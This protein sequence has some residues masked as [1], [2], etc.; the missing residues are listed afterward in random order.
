[1]LNQ[2]PF[3]AADFPL[4]S[5]E[6]AMDARRKAQGH[7]TV[8]AEAARQLKCPLAARLNDEYAL[9][10]ELRDPETSDSGRIRLSRDLHT[11][12]SALWLVPLALQFGIKLDLAVVERK[13]E[14]DIALNG[15]I[16][17]DSAIARFALAFTQDSPA[18]V[19]RYISQHY[20]DL[21]KF[22]DTK[23]L[24]FLQIEMLSRAGLHEQANKQLDALLKE[25]LSDIDET[26]LRTIVAEAHG[27]DPI[28]LRKARFKETDS[29]TDLIVLVGELETLEAWEDLCQ[30]GRSLF[31]RTRSVAD[32]ERLASALSNAQRT[33]ELLD[34]F[35]D[36]PELR[37]QSKA[38]QMYYC[39]GLYHEGLLLES[40]VELET[41]SEQSDER[42]YRAL[43]VNLGIALGD[44]PSLSSFVAAEYRSRD[45]R[46]A[47]D[48]IKIAQLAHQLGS[49][50]A[51]DLTFAAAAKG[52][53]DAGVLAAAYFLASEAGWEDSEEVAAWLHKAAELSGDD[54]PIRMMSFQEL[55]ERKPEWD[56]RES[57][58]WR[59]L[60]RGDVPMFLAGQAIN[61]S[62]INFMLFPALA[63]LSERDPRRRGAIPAYSGNRQSVPLDSAV[64][65]AG[66][67]ATALLTL[68]FLKILDKTL[69]AF[70]AV[71]IPHSTL[72]WLFEEKQMATFH[73]PSRI[74]DAH[75]IR[76]LLATDILEKF[77]PSTVA[78]SELSVQVGDELAL[79]IAEAQRLRDSDSR[80]RI[81]VRPS[82]VH[83]LS[84][85]MAEEAD[86]S[87]HASVMSSCL[88]VVGK[89]R[90]KGQI[91]ADEEK[92]AQAYLQLHERP[93]P[94]QP[95][96]ADGAVL[97]LD[98]VATAYFLHLD[99]LEKLQAAGFTVVVSRNEVSESNT[100]ISYEAIS[101]KV[102]E[103]IERIRSAVSSRIESGKIKVGARRR[104]SQPKD[105]SKYEHPTIGTCALAV[106]CNA[107]I[108]DDRFV[109]QHANAV[110]GGAQAVML[111]TLD[112][113]DAMV[114]HDLISFDD[115]FECR[116]LLRRAGYFFIPVRGDELARHLNASSVVEGKVIE[117]AELKAIRENLLCIRMSNWLQL[118]KEALWLD[119]TLKAFIRVLK[120]LWNPGADPSSVTALSDWIVDQID[121]RGWAHRMDSEA[122]DDIVKMGPG[123]HIL[124]LLTPPIDVPVDVIDAY[125]EWV[126]ERVLA[127]IKEQFPELY[128]GIIDWERRQIADMADMDLIEGESS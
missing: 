70:D 29:L 49:S 36:L 11:P 68:S 59:M 13:I 94:Q 78:D 23:A 128:A 102:N 62:L 40:R 125:W 119:S 71:Y 106:H 115:Y 35:R 48:L 113:L 88:S 66:I 67:D 95:N 30:F 72:I 12:E 54:G 86:L 122:G 105:D 65:T 6:V 45:K 112:L 53:D 107:V 44:W 121:V 64:T 98:D 104:R 69:D 31:E 22:L 89:L 79:L 81:V 5:D 47:D 60:N 126:E 14:L 43:M 118:P 38:I 17:R 63:N 52:N 123:A 51:K 96:I 57:E 46:T 76:H 114:A 75:Q 50:R 85:L 28:E 100:F 4:A 41:L 110:D 19:A 55:A 21:S 108:Y 101:G 117:T 24:R 92:R 26:R 127:P 42:N 61:R 3:E 103:A 10:L 120:S 15:G 39:W 32:A 99:L 93:W 56:R 18:H 111:S 74:R 2:L 73:Q 7:F 27:A 58:T 124:M 37:T 25:G 82:P 9:W 34:I 84:S 91:T 20:D 77:V 87:E 1:M 80:Q 116:T 33:P 16:T 97:Y 8:S 90:L 109:N 83:R